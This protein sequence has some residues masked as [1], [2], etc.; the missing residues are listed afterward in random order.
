M[1]VGLC[2]ADCAGHRCIDDYAP[3]VGNDDGALIRLLDHF[4]DD[5]RGCY[6]RVLMVN[7]LHERLPSLPLVLQATCNKFTRADV[8]AQWARAREL[9]KDEFADVLDLIGHGSDGD[10]RRFLEQLNRMTTSKLGTERFR[11]VFE[12]FRMSAA[13]NPD[14]KVYGIDSQDTYHNAKKM[15]SPMDVV[16][17]PSF[18]NGQHSA[19]W[20][21]FRLVFTRF[22]PD[23]HG[24]RH[25]DVKRSDR[26][27]VRLVIVTSARKCRRCLQLLREQPDVGAAPVDTLGTEKWLEL[28]SI[29]LRIFFSKKDS[30][31]TRYKHASMVLNFLKIKR[32]YIGKDPDKMGYKL[33]TN[34]ESKETFQHLVLSL[35]SAA[36]KMRLFSKNYT[37]VPLCLW[38]SGSDCNEE[39][40]SELAGCGKLQINRREITANDALEMAGDL[41]QLKC[42]EF[43]PDVP[44]VLG[45]KNE[46]RSFGFEDHDAD[47]GA[48]ADMMARLSDD[49]ERRLGA[50]GLQAA[51]K[52]AEE[53]GMKPA[54]RRVWFET[55]WTQDKTLGDQMRDADADDESEPSRIGDASKGAGADDA[56]TEDG[57]PSDGVA[58]GVWTE[59]A[60]AIEAGDDNAEL[61]VEENADTARV[62]GEIRR[63]LDEADAL[64]EE[65]AAAP[66]PELAPASAPEPPKPKMATH[67][68]VPGRG[69]V[70]KQTL[71]TQANMAFRKGVKL[72]AD[73]LLRVQQSAK[74]GG[75][76]R[77]G[78][79]DE[80]EPMVGL[81]S[82]V[83]IAFGSGR[84]KTW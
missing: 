52:M 30:V 25:E 58:S 2:G 74:Q 78:A 75:S 59:A 19:M 73:R 60:G 21:H 53:L 36:L 62:R 51:Q 70:H 16:S 29:Y 38:K 18:Q 35:E 27:S 65:R 5:K 12:G 49:D 20:N 79:D 32:N 81:Q 42:L 26:Q 7:P 47:G 76:V 15:Q 48:N 8:A 56:V 23:E 83:A 77:T 13:L 3:I 82:D 9:W 63:V 69:W 67:L 24:L 40:F 37:D 64:P 44:L 50:E 54:Q 14:G 1:V 55:P 57:D 43:D 68:D 22:T 34:A 84:A 72:S 80:D 11:C 10:G 61:V 41:V 31:A 4:S 71:C 17:R 28:V 46:K 33:K 6:L 66:S 45:R 39:F